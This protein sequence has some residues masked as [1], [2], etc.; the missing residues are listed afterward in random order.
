MAL[1]NQQI[2]TGCEWAC[3]AAIAYVGWTRSRNLFLS[4]VVLGALY[5]A[6]WN[7]GSPSS[8]GHGGIG[9]GS[10]VERLSEV[11]QPE[12]LKLALM[13]SIFISHMDHS[14]FHRFN[15]YAPTGG[16]LI[17]CLASK[18]FLQHRPGR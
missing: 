11:R 17:G 12:L 2:T 8:H 18:R 4:G 5:H 3:R 14:L 15:F 9:C 13:T 1:T 7:P 10:V 16:W 6:R